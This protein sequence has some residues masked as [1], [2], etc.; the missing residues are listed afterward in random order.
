MDEEPRFRRALKNPF[1]MMG[2]CLMAGIVVYINVFEPTMSSTVAPAI[3]RNPAPAKNLMTTTSSQS[4]HEEEALQWVDKPDRDPFAPVRVAKS[5]T[6]KTKP[7]SKPS[8]TFAASSQVARKSEML[9]LTL[10]AVALESDHRS[11][12]I[13]RQVVYEG[14]TIEGYHV[15][16][17]ELQGVWLQRYGHK[18]FLTFESNSTSS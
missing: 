15:V 12:V 14:E 6:D 18:E 5:V 11:A 1:V 16:S 13:N 9:A 2:L 4:A 7:S 8:R 17:I 10:K 3:A